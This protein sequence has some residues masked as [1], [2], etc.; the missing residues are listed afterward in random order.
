MVLHMSNHSLEHVKIVGGKYGGMGEDWVLSVGVFQ[1]PN[2]MA[3]AM[4][5]MAVA[6]SAK[7]EF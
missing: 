3:D 4:M 6:T 7:L 5:L 1:G 2:C